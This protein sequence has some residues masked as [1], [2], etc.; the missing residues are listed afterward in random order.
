[1]LGSSGNQ[2]QIKEE[3]ARRRKR[4]IVL[5]LILVLL[6]FVWGFQRTGVIAPIPGIPAEIFLLFFFI[7]LIPANRNWSCPACGRAFGRSGGLN[8]SH[9][10]YCQVP[11]R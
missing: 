3:F 10:R 9:C 7:L 1:M 6:A 4:Q 8:P 5:T 2:A 11:L